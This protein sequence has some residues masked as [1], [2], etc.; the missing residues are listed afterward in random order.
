MTMLTDLVAKLAAE[1]TVTAIV[2]T[3]IYPQILPQAPTFPAITYNQVSALRVRDLEGP[4]G[5][6][7]HRIS[8]NCWALTYS[9]ARGLADAVRRSIDG[10]GSS[11][12][13]DTW[14]GSVTLDNE[15]DL[16]EE[17]AGRPNVG[18]YRVVQDYI[19]SH[20]ET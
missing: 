3:R 15:M 6:S 17:D 11:F 5:K 4:A 18:I 7:R 16:F 19:I 20:L 13:S 8:I 10:Y 12:M 14:V 1:S 9:A 2:S